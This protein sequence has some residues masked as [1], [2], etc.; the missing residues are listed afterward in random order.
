M[1]VLSSLEQ[2]VMFLAVNNGFLAERK[3]DYA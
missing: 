2:V 3:Q 1:L